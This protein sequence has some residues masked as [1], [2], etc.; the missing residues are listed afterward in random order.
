MNNYSG[1]P[2]RE[3]TPRNDGSG[4][5]RVKHRMTKKMESRTNKYHHIF[6]FFGRG[7]S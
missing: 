2:R 1:L 5:F 3:Y 7:L 6:L 4:E